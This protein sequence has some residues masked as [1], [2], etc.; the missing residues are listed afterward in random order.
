MVFWISGYAP[1]KYNAVAMN[2]P[3]VSV[4]AKKKVIN[5]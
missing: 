5:Y 2:V 1:K 3:V 4:P